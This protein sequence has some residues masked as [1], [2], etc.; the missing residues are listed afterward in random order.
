MIR[1]TQALLRVFAMLALAVI[2]D[3]AARADDAANTAAQGVM[4][5]FMAAFNAK[6]GEAWA[7][8]LLYPHVRF[9]GGK[10]TTFPDR[11][12]FIAA[13]HIDA[14]I[15]G[16]GWDHSKWDSMQ[17][18]QT[19]PTKV[20]IAVEFSRYH[21]DGTKYASYPSL[22]IVEQVDGRWGIRARSSFAP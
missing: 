15:A 19:S 16:E 6:D 10:V 7:D 18:V 17:I 21:K 20:H 14:L 5:A 8:T 2:T 9:A 3:A 12:A 22:Y 11:A 13:N 4:D 1:S